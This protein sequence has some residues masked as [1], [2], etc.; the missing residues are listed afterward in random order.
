MLQLITILVIE[1]EYL[2]YIYLIVSLNKE[3]ISSADLIK[4]KEEKAKAIPLF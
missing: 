4:K 3:R 2:L 1:Q